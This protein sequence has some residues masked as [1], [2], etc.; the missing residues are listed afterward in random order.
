MRVH[1]RPTHPAYTHAD[2][3]KAHQPTGCFFLLPTALLPTGGQLQ[4]HT[5]TPA[6][7]AGGIT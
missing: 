7:P 1:C 4:T 6:R 3:Q 2:R 5:G